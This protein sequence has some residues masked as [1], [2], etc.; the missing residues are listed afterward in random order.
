MGQK[1]YRESAQGI[2]FTS[3][4]KSSFTSLMV[5]GALEIHLTPSPSFWILSLVYRAL[6][7]IKYADASKVILLLSFEIVSMMV[8]LSEEFPDFASTKERKAMLIR[9][10]AQDA[11]FQ[12]SSTIFWVAEG[13]LDCVSDVFVLIHSMNA[14]AGGISMKQLCIKVDSVHDFQDYFVK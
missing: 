1:E 5:A 7:A 13:Y 9:D 10:H 8:F 4:S 12:I 2:I 6:S 3:L 11:L 14:K